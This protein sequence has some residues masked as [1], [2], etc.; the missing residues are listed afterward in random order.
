[1]TDDEVLLKSLKSIL[2]GILEERSEIT[3]NDDQSLEIAE[4]LDDNA[5]ILDSLIPEITKIDDLYNLEEDEF[6][7]IVE[8]LQDYSENFIIDGR[9]PEKLQEDEAEYSQLMDIL[10]NFYDDEDEEE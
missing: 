9:S 2:K 6:E 7:F 10:F 8:M 3:G 5:E 1:M 4:E